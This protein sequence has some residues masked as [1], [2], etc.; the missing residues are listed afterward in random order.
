MK[1]MCTGDSESRQKNILK[2]LCRG[3]I[4]VTLKIT[5][6]CL[7]KLKVVHWKLKIWKWKNERTYVHIN[8]TENTK[9]ALLLQAPTTWKQRRKEK[10]WKKK[11]EKKK[12]KERYSHADLPKKLYTLK[13]RRL[14]ERLSHP[15]HPWSLLNGLSNHKTSMQQLFWS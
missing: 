9:N 1:M 11:E 2:K 10:R 12:K 13:H 6:T 5:L 7:T 14:H 8:N 15:S 3:H 4:S